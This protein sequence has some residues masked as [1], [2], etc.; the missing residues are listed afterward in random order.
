MLNAETFRPK[1][2]YVWFAL[3]AMLSVGLVAEALVRGDYSNALSSALFGSGLTL[4]GWLLF[5]RP[6]VVLGDHGITITNSL[7][8][9]TVGWHEVEQIETRYCLSVT[10]EGKKIYAVA[11]PAPGRY[12]ART[13]HPEEVKGLAFDN[14]NDLRAG[15][16]PR[17]H[18]GVAAQMARRRWL[19]YDREGAIEA[20]ES[21]T[22]RTTGLAALAGALVAG[23]LL[24]QIFHL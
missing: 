16:S 24:L 11:A 8:E 15:D 4:G 14:P 22:R 1:S 13:I 9:T 21:S 20:V 6:K 23:S 7:S 17:T 12:H 2:G 5:V 19:A 18:S 3:T 10:V